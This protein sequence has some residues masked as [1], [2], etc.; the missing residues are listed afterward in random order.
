MLHL[1]PLARARWEMADRQRQPGLVGQ[2]LQLPFPQPQAPA[3]AATAIGGDQQ[4]TR[5]RIQAAA[6]GT[7]P[8]ADRRNRERAR[9]MV[10]AHVDEAGVAPQVVDAVGIGTR[11][12][13]TGK[14]MSVDLV[15]R[16]LFA[17]LT[18]LVL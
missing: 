16:P 6:L 2:A 13:G 11:H 3:V 14:I 5:A 8:T 12:F 4:A 9:V 18:P 15:C 10:R 7:P 17:P 1:V